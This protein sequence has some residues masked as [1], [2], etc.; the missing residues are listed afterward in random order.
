ME[1]VINVEARINNLKKRL[2]EKK[3][4]R[5]KAEAN[6]EVHEKQLAEVTAQIKALGYEPDELPD[7]IAKLEASILENLT[8][9]E[10]ILN[11][12]EPISTDEMLK[13]VG[14]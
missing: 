2:E 4:E 8:E 6:L 3:N 13:R 11:E 1:N 14:A 5:N 7:V 12:A 10:R 9:A